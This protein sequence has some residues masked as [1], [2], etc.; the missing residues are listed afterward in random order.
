M[1]A[2]V[3]SAVA[4]TMSDLLHSA[5]LLERTPE[6]AAALEAEAQQRVEELRELADRVERLHAAAES[7]DVERPTR[8]Q[9][10]LRVLRA[11]EHARAELGSTV[12]E[13]QPAH[14]ELRLGP[15]RGGE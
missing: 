6:C 1:A 8:L 3:R 14:Q 4:E 9:A 13:E 15:G 2:S 11:E 10:L 7:G 5:S 12:E